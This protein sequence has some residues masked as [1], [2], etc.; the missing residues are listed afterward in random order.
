VGSGGG[1]V[2][3]PP[4][5][6][7]SSAPSDSLAGS[8]PQQSGEAK[9]LNCRLKPKFSQHAKADPFSEQ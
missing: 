6:S 8:S 4:A 9:K 1:R 3:V 7:C 2:P 5:A